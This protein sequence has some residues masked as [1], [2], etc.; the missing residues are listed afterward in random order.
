MTPLRRKCY[1]NS[2]LQKEFPF[3]KSTSNSTSIVYCEICK[4]EVDILNSGRSNINTHL[5]KK[6]HQL[7]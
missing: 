4:C 3:M 7:L 5:T 6:T 2:D 1:F